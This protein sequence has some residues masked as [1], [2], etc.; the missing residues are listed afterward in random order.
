MVTPEMPTGRLIGQAVFHDESDGQRDD[1][2]GVMAF[3]QGV[4]G[5]V[6]VE[7]PTAAS[8]TMLGVTD[9][10]VAR[11]AGDQVPHVVEDSQAC[12]AAETGFATYRARPMS[13]V[14]AAA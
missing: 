13:E 11:A 14:P 5:H 4:V 9:F 6:R 10:D 1:A 8:A 7:V 2:M 12:A 3:G